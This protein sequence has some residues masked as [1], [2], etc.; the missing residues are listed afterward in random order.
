MQPLCHL[1][2]TFR[3]R[4]KI[5]SRNIT[6]VTQ[7][8]QGNTHKTHLVSSVDHFPNIYRIVQQH[9]RFKI[10]FKSELLIVP[11]IASIVFPPSLVCNYYNEDIVA[12][13]EVSTPL[14][15]RKRIYAFMRASWSFYKKFCT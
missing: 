12:Q 14:Q 6:S 11:L 5:P 3:D 1:L 2:C 13:R 10:K 7:T 8:N 9:W 4:N 15:A